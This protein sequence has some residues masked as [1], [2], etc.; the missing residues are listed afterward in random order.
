MNYSTLIK[1]NGKDHYE[2]VEQLVNEESKREGT[3]VMVFAPDN[4]SIPV[5]V[6]TKAS[7][8]SATKVVLPD[9]FN[10]LLTFDTIRC[11]GILDVP[12]DMVLIVPECDRYLRYVGME[13]TQTLINRLVYL[14]VRMV[15]IT[16]GGISEELEYEKVIEQS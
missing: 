16:D 12:K 13:L 7:V 6:V 4:V 11:S 14:G 2:I 1:S 10:V 9:I 3:K 8:I 5:T 15:F